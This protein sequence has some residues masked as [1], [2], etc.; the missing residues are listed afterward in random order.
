MK[1]VLA[2]LGQHKPF[3]PAWCKALT[4]LGHKVF[5]YDF[6]K[7]LR[8][9]LLGRIESRLLWGPGLL[10]LNQNLIKEVRVQQPDVVLIHNGNLVRQRTIEKLKSI[11]WVAGFQHDDSFGAFSKRIHFRNYRKTIPLYDSHHVIREINIDDYKALN[12]QN[13]SLL[14]TYY[15]PWLHYPLDGIRKSFDVVFIGHAEKDKRL[16]YVKHLV[17]KGVRLQ[18]FGPAKYWHRYLKKSVIDTLP[19][20]RPVYGEQY[21]RTIAQSKICLAFYSTANRDDYA[22]RVFEI[23]ACRGFLLAR[24]TPLMQELY[25]E[26]EEVVLFSSPSELYEKIQYHL[27]HDEQRVEIARKGYYRALQSEYDVVSKMK[28]WIDETSNY[29]KQSIGN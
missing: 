8:P 4:Q 5:F 16:D 15:V 20:I 25:K 1:I 22:Y 26:D 9:G 18:I 12:V 13:V 17:N 14:R 3:A 19:P 23:P 29:M 2:G 27:A 28:Q 10:G 21:V 11:T 7:Q 24:R 6:Q